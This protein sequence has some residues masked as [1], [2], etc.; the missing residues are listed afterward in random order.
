MHFSAKDGRTVIHTQTIYCLHTKQGFVW[1]LYNFQV[2]AWH[3]QM[4]A[5]RSF[6]SYTSYWYSP[7]AASSLTGDKNAR[8][9]IKPG[10]EHS[11]ESRVKWLKV[12]R[13]DNQGIFIMCH[14]NRSAVRLIT[15]GKWGQQISIITQ[16]SRWVIAVFSG[17]FAE[18]SV[19]LP[20][21]FSWGEPTYAG[22][23][24]LFLLIINSVSCLA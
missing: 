21:R 9:G 3:C 11:V 15:G 13:T 24:A 18:A 16:A 10:A 2:H 6:Y 19:W 14:L 22:L 5:L 1:E 20:A 17:S 8:W 7:R 23:E 12:T 4:D